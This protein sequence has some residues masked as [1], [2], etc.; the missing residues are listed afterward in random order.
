VVVAH[1]GLAEGLL[2]ALARVAGEQ[3]N[4][5]PL[6]NQ[7]LGGEELEAR[8]R[9]ILADRGAGRDA[10][11]LSDMDGGSCG[12]VCRRLLAEGVVRAVFFGV[13]LPLLF[14]FVFVQD[15]SF[16]RFTTLV[17]EKA[18]TALGAHR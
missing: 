17:V 11:L 9:G 4:L 14:E 15:E 8:I 12:Q 2:S 7:G 10:Y 13:N 5:W 3:E 6:S 16:E 18:R 1:G